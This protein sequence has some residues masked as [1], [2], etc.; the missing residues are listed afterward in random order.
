MEDG[1]ALR[2]LFEKPPVRVGLR[3][4]AANDELVSSFADDHGHV[5]G[6]RAVLVCGDE[7]YKGVR[8]HERKGGSAVT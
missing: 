2:I 1:E 3:D 8:L 6:E 5:A 4:V 7:N